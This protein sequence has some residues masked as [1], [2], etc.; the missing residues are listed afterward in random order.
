[1]FKKW[2]AKMEWNDKA[3]IIGIILFTMVCQSERLYLSMKP[4]NHETTDKT[5]TTDS[6]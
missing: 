2:I 6:E 1:M 4:R 3:C 5:E